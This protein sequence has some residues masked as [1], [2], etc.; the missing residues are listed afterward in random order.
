MNKYVSSVMVAVGSFF[1]LGFVA[2]NNTLNTK[3]VGTYKGGQPAYKLNGVD[4]P[5]SEFSFAISVTNNSVNV[6]QTII[7]PS[8]EANAE[9]EIIRYNGTYKLAH[10]GA[11]Y[12]LLCSVVEL[13]MKL[14]NPTYLLKVSKTTFSGTCTPS[15]EGEPVFNILKAGYI[16]KVGVPEKVAADCSGLEPE[17]EEFERDRYSKFNPPMECQ[18]IDVKHL[19]NCFYEV[20]AVVVDPATTKSRAV[21]LKYKFNKGDWEISK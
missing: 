9:P 13:P 3:Y 11:S 5:S 19:M 15:R 6:A 12:K 7:D 21:K 16:K 4:M 14:S 17:L 1:L 10:D 20:N 2:E 8:A 18:K